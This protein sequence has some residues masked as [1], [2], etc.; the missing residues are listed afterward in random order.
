MALHTMHKGGSTKALRYAISENPWFVKAGSIVP[1]ASPDLKN[2][3]E[4]SNVLGILVVPGKGKSAFTLYEDDGVSK[5]Y[6]NAF[7]RTL[8]E[9]NR[10]GNKLTLTIHPREGSFDGMSP[11][12]EVYIVLEGVSAE[13]RAIRCNGSAAGECKK[14]GS[15]VKV[16]LPE[17]PSDKLNIIEITL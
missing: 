9:K 4:P 2:L 5:D 14:E 3:Q 6:E 11:E 8:I 15:S 10:S 7:A 13:P 12:R 16:S 17:L 1:L